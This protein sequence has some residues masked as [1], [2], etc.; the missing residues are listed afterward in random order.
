AISIGGDPPSEVPAWF[1]NVSPGWLDTM[2]IPFISGRDFVPTDLS[3]G[4][5]IV[6][7]AFARQFFVNE[8]PVGKWFEGTSGWMQGQRFQIVGLVHNARYRHLRQAVL[9]VAYTPFRRT[10]AKGT[11]QGGT[12][13]VRTFTS[14]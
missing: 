1:M 2:K 8:N 3:P 7:E 5:A 11:I 12:F 13:V 6:N 14:N 9:P 10:E 4:A